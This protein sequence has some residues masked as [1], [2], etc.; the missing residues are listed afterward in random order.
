MPPQSLGQRD[1][2]TDK[3]SQVPAQ[4]EVENIQVYCVKNDL[5]LSFSVFYLGATRQPGIN[6]LNVT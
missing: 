3:Y 5:P 1:R 6:G 4:P 2:Q